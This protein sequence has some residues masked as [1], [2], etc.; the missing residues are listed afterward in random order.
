MVGGAEETLNAADTRDRVDEGE[1]GERRDDVPGHQLVLL[2]RY[3]PLQEWCLLQ[4]DVSVIDALVED[5][6]HPLG[7][8]TVR[9]EEREKHWKRK[10][11]LTSD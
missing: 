9:G 6:P 4:D 11:T 1:V 8:L 2:L 10:I 5:V 7:H 3:L